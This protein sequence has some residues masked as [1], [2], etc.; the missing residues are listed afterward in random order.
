MTAARAWWK[1]A[2]VYQIYPRSFNDSDGDGVGDLQ[3][4]IERLDYVADLGVDVIW[5]NPVYD[6]PQKD[7]GYD[8]S[9]YQTIY[10][11]FGTM[12]DW[13]ALVEE[14]HNRDMRLV[15]DLVVN[16]TS[17]QHEWFRKSRQRDPEYEDYY[18]WREGGTDEDGD[19]VENASVA[20][21]GNYTDAGEYETDADGTVD[22]ISPCRP[23]RS[24][25]RR[26]IR[27]GRTSSTPSSGGWR[28]ASTHPDGDHRQSKRG[29]ARGAGRDEAPK[30]LVM[31]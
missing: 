31:R 6:S 16:H 24:T 29:A 26:T 9:D 2:V 23:S 28:R 10:D 21:D 17:D 25:W 14:V 20:V 8:I 1:E 4:I 27:S 22:L 18:I 7:N 11:E 12:A 5:L 13:E 19:P 15:M 30:K 3:G